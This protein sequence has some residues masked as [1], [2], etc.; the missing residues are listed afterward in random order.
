MSNNK[1][2]LGQSIRITG[3]LEAD[4]ISALTFET[5]SFTATS[6]TYYE[7]VIVDGDLTVNGTT[8]T[9]DAES[10]LLEDNIIELNYGETGTPLPTLQSG[11]KVNRGDYEPYVFLFDESTYTFRI[12]ESIENTD[13][14]YD[15]LNLQP[16]ATREDSPID[17][18]IA[19]WDNTNNRIGTYSNILIDVTS[20]A[21]FIGFKIEGLSINKTSITDWNNA[22]HLSGSETVG[23]IKTFSSFPLT[24]S[25][26]PTS[27]YQAANKKYVDDNGG[28]ITWSTPVDSSISI[29]TNVAYN[30]GTA[31]TNLHT[32]YTYVLQI[33]NGS[34]LEFAVGDDGDSNTSLY[35]SNST[36]SVSNGS[37][38]T[39]LGF[40]A[41]SILDSSD[42]NVFIG[43]NAGVNLVGT[44]N[45]AI[46]S[47][48]ATRSS[49]SSYG[50]HVG[51]YAGRYAD[52]AYL[53]SFGYN[54]GAGTSDV[55]GSRNCSFGS[56][57]GS[58]LSSGQRNVLMGAFAGASTTS[59]SYNIVAGSECASLMT[60]GRYNVLMG[61]STATSVIGADYNV[62]IGP[63]A[64]KN[65][66]NDNHNTI[67]GYYAGNKINSDFNVAI[68]NYSLAY[69]A[70]VNLTGENNVAIGYRALN[71]LAG[72][73]ANN[74]A[75]GMDAGYNLITGTGNVF[76]GNE[77]AYNENASN[78][79]C[80]GN[81]SSSKLIYGYFST[82]IVQINNRLEV[83]EEIKVGNKDS[84]TTA[85]AGMIIWNSSN[86]QGY[87]GSEW[88]DL[89]VSA[90]KPTTY[91][92]LTSATSLNMNTNTS[93]N[94]KITLGHNATITLTNLSDGDEGKIIVTNGGTYT[95]SISPTPYVA[96]DG[97]GN[98][99][100]TNNGI[101]IIRYVY[102]GSFLFITVETNFT[103]T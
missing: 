94:A 100:L 63:V 57:A 7:D 45:T 83:T 90:N 76:I 21:G 4:I 10:I 17:N 75:I 78:I 64:G 69:S 16:V 27:D 34:K 72:T 25:S 92:T 1:T 99:T 86:F 46:G 81:S 53:T 50:T 36:G 95:L 6:G 80:I 5:D 73:S 52:A 65:I 87:D 47:E 31:T 49:S 24:P 101:D 97:G 14:S 29:D 41:G 37:R 9:K 35:L 28:G 56:N 68:G 11:I 48:T 82:N 22:M 8:I 44:G 19:Y 61:Y 58:K 43:Y 103:A 38:N 67:I 71:T 42:D 54:A 91:Q 3:E 23:G 39:T 96:G 74:V 60:S 18:G 89:D 33:G 59:G 93:V 77:S 12:G 51:Y 2:I 70:T 84:G 20:G 30:I 26:E 102:D 13:G 98:I 62:I 40:G 88:K 66:V 85:T 79:L 15:D 32:V 55:S